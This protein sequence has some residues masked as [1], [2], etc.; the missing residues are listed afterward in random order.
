M[1]G[2]IVAVGTSVARAL[3]GC[4]AL[5]GEIRAGSWTTNLR[6]R[7][8]CVPRVV[9]ALLTGAHSP[10]TSHYA[11]LG[12]FLPKE[13]LRSALAASETAGLL[14]HEFGDRWMIL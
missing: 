11:M 5:H 3:E 7:P 6:L 14:G 9:D 13:L 8:G 4:F 1:G 2:R 12:A 10:E